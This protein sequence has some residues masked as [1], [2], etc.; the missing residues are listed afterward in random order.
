VFT[1]PEAAVSKVKLRTP[2]R[3]ATSHHRPSSPAPRRFLA[4]CPG[5]RDWGEAAAGWPRRAG[6]GAGP[7]FCP[8]LPTPRR[9]RFPP[10]RAPAHLHA[11]HTEGIALV[12]GLV[13]RKL[14]RRRRRLIMAGLHRGR[15]AAVLCQG[16][17]CEWRMRLGLG[18]ALL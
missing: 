14:L 5:H 10:S 18:V 9:P 1:P 4:A 7:A 2:C 11:L 13:A 17:L 15:G 12:S 6:R 16:S 8:G 3:P